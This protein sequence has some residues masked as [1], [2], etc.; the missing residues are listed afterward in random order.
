MAELKEY[1]CEG[2]KREKR[3][4]TEKNVW[5]VIDTF[6]LLWPSGAVTTVDVELVFSPEINW[7]NLISS[8]WCLAL[9]QT[10]LIAMWFI[11]T[12]WS[13]LD[14]RIWQI[15]RDVSQQLPSVE[16]IGIIY[17]FNSKLT[18]I[19]RNNN[20]SIVLFNVQRYVLRS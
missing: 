18:S 12:H 3:K 2:E 7:C 13:C 1:V 6:S 9:Y 20:N 16:C 15:Y 14:Y 19:K 5:V 8:T 11:Q 10:I 4:D 17:S